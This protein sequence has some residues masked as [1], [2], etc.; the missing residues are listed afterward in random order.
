MQGLQSDRNNHDRPVAFRTNFARAVLDD[1]V[2]LEHDVV[3]GTI[4]GPT[5]RKPI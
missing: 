2:V 1:A 5:T 3:I 4:S